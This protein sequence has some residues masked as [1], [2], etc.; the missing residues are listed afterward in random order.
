MF[1]EPR[2]KEDK[3]Q[4]VPKILDSTTNSLR[5]TSFSLCGDGGTNRKRIYGVVLFLTLTPRSSAMSQGI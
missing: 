2:E 1:P 4:T 5:A 3:K